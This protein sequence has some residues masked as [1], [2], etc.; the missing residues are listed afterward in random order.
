MLGLEFDTSCFPGRVRDQT[1][2]IPLGPGSGLG[3]ERERPGQWLVGWQWEVFDIGR[4]EQSRWSL[5]E[6]FIWWWQLQ[7]GKLSDLL[8]GRE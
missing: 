3:L 5:V 7:L 8:R 2:D 6:G 1:F 4:D